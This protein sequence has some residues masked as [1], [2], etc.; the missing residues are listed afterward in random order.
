MH[1]LLP[2]RI[3]IGDQLTGSHRLKMH[4]SPLL[5]RLLVLLMFSL[6][7]WK[8]NAHLAGLLFCKQSKVG[9]MKGGMAMEGHGGS[10][11]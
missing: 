1:K 7:L 8:D 2:K 11:P 10:K 5:P 3:A 9:V 6:L 4:T